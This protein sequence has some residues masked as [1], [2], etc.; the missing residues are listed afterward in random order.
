M[1]Q[2]L[3]KGASSWVARLLLSILVVAFGLSIWQGNTLFTGGMDDTVASVGDTDVSTQSFQAAFDRQLRT[4]QQQVGGSFTRE[5]ALAFNIQGS[6]LAQLLSEA[7]VAEAAR[8]YGLRVPDDLVAREIASIPAFQD[9]AGKFD[10]ARFR[11]VL[12]QAGMTEGMLT[13]QI[14]A[15]LVRA[16]LF[17]PAAGGARTP[18]IVAQTLYAHRQQRR[19]IDYF[20]LTASA[21]GAA[22]TPDE[23]AVDAFYKANP[24]PFTAPEYRAITLLIADPAEIARTTAPTEEVIA[25]AYEERKAEFATPEKRE[26]VQIVLKTQAEADAAMTKLNAGEDFNAVAKEVA[27]LSEED[28]K[29]GAV[30]KGLLPA[31]LDEAV[32]AAAE[33]A[34]GGPVQTPLG[35]HVFKLVKVEAASTQSLE[36]VHDQIR[37]SLALDAATAQIGQI[38]KS[39]QDELAGGATLEEASQRLNLSLRKVAMIDSAG[40]DETGKEIEDLPVAPGLLP[41]LF[42]A[43]AGQDG[44][45]MDTDGGGLVIGRV[46]S[47]T[48]EA[49]RPLDQVRDQVIAAWQANDTKDR[50]TTLAAETV[51][52]I[53]EGK[54]FADA[55]RDASATVGLVGP[56]LRS[57]D[58]VFVALPPD[59][60]TALFAVDEG[61]A[62][63]AP[64]VSEAGFIIGAVR[65]IEKADPTADAEGVKALTTTLRS[66]FAGDL[67]GVFEADLRA[68]FGINVH[69]NTYNRLITPSPQ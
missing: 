38:Q 44:E 23:A 18:A 47:I 36:E 13:Q 7:T 3:R 32:F 12:Q 5:Q 26:I 16:Q 53:N 48:P 61:K 39:L 28:T 2:S 67:A 64:A 8:V 29:L 66:D 60:I 59:L 62:A 1:L 21:L 25:A 37:D 57:G 65:S 50:L 43:A 27:N 33:G 11:G 40:K 63:S 42:Q 58:A 6:V 51:K 45:M 69:E 30:T 46:D 20:T 19:T 10:A 56:G 52:A 49:L 55:A 17:G 4:I 24:I 54:P 9:F 14:R 68:R 31:A 34:V 15:E 35:W 41:S 22:V